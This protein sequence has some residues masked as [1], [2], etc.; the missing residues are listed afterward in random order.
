[1]KSYALHL[2]DLLGHEL[3][4]VEVLD[5]FDV[6]HELDT[7]GGRLGTK[8]LGQLHLLLKLDLLAFLLDAFQLTS[9]KN[10]LVRR[11]KREK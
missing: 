10:A 9:T 7:D 4:R 1:L 8:R 6:D 11:N 2:L 3:L 5:V